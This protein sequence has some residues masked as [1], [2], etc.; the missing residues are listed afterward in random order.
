MS[1]LKPTE[2]AIEFT[3]PPVPSNCKHEPPFP[4]HETVT[5]V[6]SSSL[7]VHLSGRCAIQHPHEI[8]IC[9]E[10]SP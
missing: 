1:K 4:F 6:G 7:V 2:G 8:G 10:F 9:G 5:F 3:A